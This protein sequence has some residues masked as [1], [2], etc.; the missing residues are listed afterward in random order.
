MTTTATVLFASPGAGFEAPFEMLAACH[1]RIERML[2]LLERLGAHVDGHGADTQARDAA[3][4]VMRYFDQAAPQHHEDEERHVL[5]LLRANGHAALAERLHAEHAAMV[6]AWAALRPALDA[7]REGNAAAALTPA[8]RRA[9]REFAALY[10]SHAQAEDRLA[11][12]TAQALLDAAAQGAMGREMAQRRGVGSAAQA[13]NRPGPAP[14]T[15][16]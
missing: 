14:T 1:E 2:T 8:A 7:L 3:R 10:R 4:D 9:W 15:S 6:E 5:P 11:F 16:R 13:P 12:P